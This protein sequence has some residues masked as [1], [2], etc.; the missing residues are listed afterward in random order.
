MKDICSALFGLAV[1]ASTAALPAPAKAAVVFEFDCSGPLGCFGDSGLVFTVE[2]DDSV[3]SPNGSYNT[4]TDGGAAFRRFSIASDVDTGFSFTGG[5]HD[6]SE[7][8][9]GVT[10][11]FDRSGVL[12]NIIDNEPNGFMVQFGTVD[13]GLILWDESLP[14][15]IAR[16]PPSQAF[17]QTPIPGSFQRTAGVPVPATLAL[18]TSGLLC[19]AAASGCRRRAQRSYTG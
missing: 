6:I 3:V 9:Q 16:V 17:D 13:Q 2:L 10:F 15:I 12:S 19:A 5:Y 8:P 18:L 11:T 1:L 14:G 7:I 4:D